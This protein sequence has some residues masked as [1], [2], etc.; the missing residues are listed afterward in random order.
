MSEQFT[1][2]ERTWIDGLNRGDVSVADDVFA[3]NCVIHIAGS[4]D[5]NL[6]L[7]GFKQMLDRPSCGVSGHSADDR[8]SGH[9]R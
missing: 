3:P 4:P 9:Y 5:P 1:K 7:S 8:G 2:Y 6:S